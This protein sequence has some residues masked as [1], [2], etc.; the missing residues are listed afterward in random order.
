MISTATNIRL[1]AQPSWKYTVQGMFTQY[2]VVLYVKITKYK[3][4]TLLQGGRP[5]FQGTCTHIASEREPI[6]GTAKGEANCWIKCNP[7]ADPL[8]Q[9]LSFQHSRDRRVGLTTFSRGNRCNVRRVTRRCIG[10]CTEKLIIARDIRRRDLSQYARYAGYIE[11][12]CLF[13]KLTRS[14]RLGTHAMETK[15]MKNRADP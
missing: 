9:W 5:L 15:E 14:S 11:I 10:H 13:E 7:D 3:L 6:L 2:C 1:H 4:L 12:H 8:P